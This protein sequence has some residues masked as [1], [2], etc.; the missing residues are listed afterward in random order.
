MNK[1]MAKPDSFFKSPFNRLLAA[2]LIV[3]GV[4]ALL[5]SPNPTTAPVEP[6]GSDHNV[7]VNFFFM[8]GCPHC[9][10]QAAFNQILQ[11]DYNTVQWK[12]H[13]VTTPQGNREF[14]QSIEQYH[15]HNPTF[16]V[17]MTV[18]NGQGIV[19]WTS[20]QTTGQAIRN[21]IVAA[22]KQQENQIDQDQNKFLLDL[23]FFGPTDLSTWSLPTLAIL[24]GLVDGF[25]PC[26]MWVLVYL[27]ALA[28]SLNDKRRLWLLVGSFVLA[29][30]ILY[31]LFMTAWLNAFLFLGYLR[32]VTI[33]VGLGALAGGILGLKDF[34]QTKGQLTCKIGDEKEKKKTAKRVQQLINSPLTWATLLG[35]IVLAFTVNAVE[36]ACS[37]AIPAV[38]TQ[39]LAISNLSALEHYAYIGLYTLFFMLDDLIIFG[40]AAFA[41]STAVGEKYAKYCKL[42]GGILMIAM[43]L[44][45]LFVP[46]LL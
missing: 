41:V 2:A 15:I 11:Q 42:L 16:G 20:I 40:L 28:L 18:I 21:Q 38:F 23:P 10:D 1:A 29:S 33:L 14:I 19:G 37:A 9:A 8:P 45:L 27:I 46:Q 35:I 34:I 32:P 24:L 5:A 12:L 4:A 30:G 17:P 26:A 6:A 36:F 31:F 3:L 25:N 43:G 22:L 44:A 13:D 7:M 39:V